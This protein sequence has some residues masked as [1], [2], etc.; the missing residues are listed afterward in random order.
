MDQ[1]K[2]GRISG[3]TDGGAK[4]TAVDG[5]DRKIMIGQQR[6]TQ[7]LA[8]Q[9][10][11]AQSKHQQRRRGVAPAHRTCCTAALRSA[12]MTKGQ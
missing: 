11:A 3:P 7:A 10:K 1:N 6:R 2:L 4:W 12:A 8:Y 5:M 9:Q